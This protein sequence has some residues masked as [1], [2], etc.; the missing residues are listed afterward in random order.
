M[1]RALTVALAENRAAGIYRVRAHTPP[2]AVARWAAANGWRLFYVDA[3]R[4]TDKA[5][6]IRAAGTAMGFPAYSAANWDAFEES[7]LD[8]SWAPAQGYLLVVDHPDRLIA[9]DAAAWAVA[10]QVLED[11]VQHWASRGVPW[12]VLLRKAGRALPDVPWL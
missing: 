8:L 2:R 1:T 5:S 10:R 4:V 11:A 12:L 3:G 6:F 9:A 7:L